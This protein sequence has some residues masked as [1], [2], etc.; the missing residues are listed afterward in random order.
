M[1]I[2][3]AKQLFQENNDNSDKNLKENASDYKKAASLLSAKHG[4]AIYS[5]KT[6]LLTNFDVRTDKYLGGLYLKGRAAGEMPVPLSQVI[7]SVELLGGS[8]GLSDANP[9]KLYESIG[10]ARDIL[11]KIAAVVR[12]VE[13]KQ[14]AVPESLNKSIDKTS[15]VLDKSGQGDRKE[16]MVK[17]QVIRDLKRLS[18]LNTAKQAAEEF[19]KIAQAQSWDTAIEKF[20]SRYPAK[21]ANEPN[22]FSIISL[23]DIKKASPEY[24][25]ALNF[26]GQSEPLARLLK[27]QTLKENK[28]I[29]QLYSLIP[30]SSNS[31]AELP[32]IIEVKPYMSYYLIKDLSINRLYNEQFQNQKSAFAYEA[33]AIEMQNLAAVFF[34][35][36]NIVKRMNLTLIEDS[37]QPKEVEGAPEGFEQ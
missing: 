12:V 28:F 26:R 33:D 7:F 13:L 3:D 23:S 14:A 29:E 8:A 15:L 31:P 19:S 9:P 25:N 4:T 11:G 35:P 36:E 21:D 6:G 37:K 27:K 1:I 17:E 22:T 20:N 30:A 2:N 5:G 18:A 16:V 32:V 24:L 34:Q 10:P